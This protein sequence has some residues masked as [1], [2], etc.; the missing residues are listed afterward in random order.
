MP[1]RISASLAFASNDSSGK[2]GILIVT[3]AAFTRVFS[4]SDSN[5]NEKPPHICRCMYSYPLF[6]GL[7]KNSP[8]TPKGSPWGEPFSILEKREDGS[9]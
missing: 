1:T 9:S 2:S 7:P 8:Y 4:M 5:I 3:L 6:D